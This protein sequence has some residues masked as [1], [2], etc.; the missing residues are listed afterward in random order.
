MRRKR[1]IRSR[2][3]RMKRGKSKRQRQGERRR[4]R[5]KRM[6]KGERRGIGRRRREKG[7][8]NKTKEEQEGTKEKEDAPLPRVWFGRGIDHAHAGWP[9]S[10]GAVS[11]G[12]QTEARPLHPTRREV[13]NSFV[14]DL[15]ATS[16]RAIILKRDPSGRPGLSL[17]SSARAVCLLL[18]VVRVFL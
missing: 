11:P 10:S 18:A 7:E 8:K 6:R 16:P 13:C 3:R 2:R 1:R 4:R 15:R 5:R 9:G 12:R 14:M 17:S